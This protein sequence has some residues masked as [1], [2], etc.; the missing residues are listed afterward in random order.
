MPTILFIS[1]FSVDRRVWA[2]I[3]RLIPQNFTTEFYEQK[4]STNSISDSDLTNSSKL[5]PA[6]GTFTVVVSAGNGSSTAVALALRGQAEALLLIE[7]ALDSIP[8]EL[9]PVDFSGLGALDEHMPRYTALV[10]AAQ[11][12]ADEQTWRQLWLDVAR[13]SFPETLSSVDRELLEAIAVDHA[14]DIYNM[15]SEG[16]AAIGE[17]RQWPPPLPA[18]EDGWVERLSDVTVPVAIMSDQ[19]QSETARVLAARALRGSVVIADTAGGPVWLTNRQQ[20]IELLTS[21]LP[22]HGTRS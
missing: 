17:G 13:S 9:T 22:G 19:R 1:G 16:I 21:L 5:I 15:M 18:E 3:P 2:D 20:T 11:R 8:A 14:R 7:P 6:N 12:G 4:S 10:S